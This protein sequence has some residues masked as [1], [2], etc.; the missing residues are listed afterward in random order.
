MKGSEP[1]IY[2]ARPC[3]DVIEFKRKR[4]WKVKWRRRRLKADET[5][6]KVVIKQHGLKFATNAPACVFLD[7]PRTAVFVSKDGIVVEYSNNAK[8]PNLRWELFRGDL[9]VYRK[10]DNFSEDDLKRFFSKLK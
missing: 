7:D 3:G 6:F 5:Y 10:D 8:E 1:V 9:V 2:Y 4:N